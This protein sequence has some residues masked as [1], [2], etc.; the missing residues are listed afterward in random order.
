MS[1]RS[2][3]PRNFLPVLLML[4]A[5]GAAA[6]AGQQARRPITRDAYDGWRSI[7][8]TTLSRDGTWLAYALVPQEGDGELVAL[9]LRTGIERRHARGKDPVITADGR[10]LVFTIA[11][12]QAEIDRAKKE[13]KSPDEGPKAGLGILTLATGDVA[14]VD[15]V[16]SFAVPAE[17][18]RVAAYLREPP[19]TKP[20]AEKAAGEE[21]AKKSGPKKEPG[22]DLIV[23]DL[24]SGAESTIPEVVEY[25]WSA[26]GDWLAYAASSTTPA[27]DGVFA[28]RTSDGAMHAL[29]T[30]PG[31]Y[32]RLTF[33]EKGT[34]LAFV[35]DRDQY[36]PD[37]S[38]YEL[39]HWKAGDAQ[40]LEI[41][42]LAARGLPEGMAVSEHGDL[43]FSR[44]GARLFLGTAPA[45]VPEPEDAPE[46]VAV[47][48][49]HWKDPLLQPMQKVRAE[50]ERKRSYRA[51]V[52]LGERRFVQLATRD[53]P[54]VEP[55][56]A[57]RLLGS[58]QVGYE[59]LISWDGEY[60]DVY[61][62]SAR[63]GS[64]QKV[65]ER[66]HFDATLSPGGR[67]LLY[68]DDR[69]SSWY[70]RRVSDGRVVNLTAK[71]GVTFED[72][73]W[74]TPDQPR[75]YGLAGW[76]ADDA[77]VL[78]YDRF[79]I[80]D[81]DPDG[82]GARMLTG[83]I[84]RAQQLVFRY[85]P[86]D[87]DERAIPAGAPLLLRT[88]DHRTKA[89]GYY[90]V[91]RGAAQ[92]SKVIMLDKAFGRLVKAKQADTLVF[93][94]SRFEEFPD[95]WVS[96]GAFAGL[97]KVS[98]ANPQ[99][100]LYTWGT[101]EIIDYRNAD[102][103]PLRALL[104][105][106]DDFD[107]AKT[108]PLMV[109]IYEE[110]TNGLHD[111]VPPAPSHR[112][113]R[114]RY[115]SNGYLVLMPD[116][117]YRTGYPGESALKCVVPAVQRVIDMGFVDP[118][119]VGIQGHSWGGYQIS[120]M[121]TRT[122]MFR[123][124]EAGASVVNMISAYGGIRWETGRSRAFQYERTQSRIGAPPWE[125]PL[126]F[127]ENSPIFW[128]ERVKTPYLTMHN[129]DD[130]AVPWEQGI[131]FFT[132]LRRLGKE[133]YL[134]NYNGEKHG[135][136]QRAN[137]KHFAVHMDEFFDHYLKGAP[138]PE[139]MEK[140]VPYLDRGTRDVTPLYR[141]SSAGSS[142]AAASAK[143]GSGVR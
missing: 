113:N 95:L 77:A 53:V 120:Y 88:T 107:P 17:S 52:H 76:T 18:G 9:N 131:E 49:W 129:D 74:D 103:L 90:R 10:F 31:H 15:R 46:P 67:Y 108:Y 137:Q 110:L 33:D 98:N 141:P 119:R 65:L 112:I 3:A 123:A 12:L 72:E 25:A 81:I 36:R 8:G 55:G 101:G 11:P 56:E 125:R 133:A 4:L 24:A 87:P 114:T 54:D 13:K 61:L 19:Q 64:R 115:V 91:A 79:D 66:Q 78:I 126:Q 99:Q 140:G 70:S 135:L 21:S 29:A 71:L 136:R 117:V 28:R 7:E 82:G 38:A 48:L 97:R 118:Q 69:D 39:Y 143:A 127:I 27:R 130:G 32:K 89:S 142:G 50:E 105:K 44:D 94:L 92:P 96:D 104:F 73:T 23:R 138:R 85:Q 80:W 68:Y 43:K 41:V 42:S 14:T 26:G 34:Q 58:T 124:V 6:P 60:A 57:D 47:D 16:K 51:V 106:P 139:W 40:A 83:G 62:V 109:Y 35:S 2:I 132:A 5:V 75:P 1:S 30:G 116:I 93:T 121:I 102:G 111:Y 45:P 22:T 122:D 134:F 59:P 128:V 86:L 84:G 63:D 100:A 20:R 37:A